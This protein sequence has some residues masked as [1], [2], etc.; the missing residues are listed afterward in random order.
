MR[1]IPSII[2]LAA[3]AALAALLLAGC[4]EGSSKGLLSMPPTQKGQEE[5]TQAQLDSLKEDSLRVFYER[6]RRWNALHGGILH[7]ESEK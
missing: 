6:I 4:Q 5:Q 1:R 3:A 2:I 7:R